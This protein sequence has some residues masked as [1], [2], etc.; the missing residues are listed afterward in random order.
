M[1]KRLYIGNLPWESSD[2]DIRVFFEGFEV[3]SVKLISDHETGR[4]KGFGFVE[5]RDARQCEEAIACLDGREMGGR[6]IRVSEAHERQGAPQGGRGDRG[7][8]PGRGR[9]DQGSWRR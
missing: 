7:G 9:R 3:T 1:G 2:N 8:G 4:P 6:T 5:L